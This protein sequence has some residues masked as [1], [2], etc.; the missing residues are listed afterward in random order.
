MCAA[1]ATSCIDSRAA[2]AS[3]AF[4]RRVAITRSHLKT[5]LRILISIAL[6]GAIVWVLGGVRELASHLLRLQPG[7][8]IAVLGILTLDRALMAYKWALLLKDRGIHVPF[9]RAM[10]A[11]CSSAVWGLLLPSSLGAD[12]I[13]AYA[14]ARRERL[15]AKPIVASIVVER[16]VGFF[17]AL[18]LAIASL[19]ILTARASLGQ[20]TVVAWG[21]AV[22]MML[23]GFAAVYAS[24]SRWVAA[25]LYDR[26][27]YRARHHRI[28]LKVRALHESYRTFT[29]SRKTLV[30]FFALSLVEQLIPILELWLIAHAMGLGVGF[31]TLVASL[32]LAL[33]F[34]RLPISFDGIGV[35]EGMFILLMS[36]GGITG[37]QAAA[38]AVVSRILGPIAYLPWWL[39][40]YTFQRQALAAARSAGPNPPPGGFPITGG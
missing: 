23:A 3:P 2:P 27:L 32:P 24:M 37:A 35:F 40:D 18:V 17:S 33:L 14:I 25:F 30:R 26:L 29:T 7:L 9:V 16:V 11:Y 38:I 13:R 8:V 5:L 31:L 12:A 6:L 39:A 19:G 1:S 22:A 34:A 28:I 15:D 20:E 4:T 36:L 21:L 10:T